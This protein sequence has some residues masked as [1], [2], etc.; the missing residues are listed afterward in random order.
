METWTWSIATM[1]IPEGYGA[2]ALRAA[3]GHLAA[4]HRGRDPP[5]VDDREVA[6]Q[7]G[8]Q[9]AEAV[10]HPGRVGRAPRAGAHRPRPGHRQ[11]GVPARPPPPA[12]PGLQAQPPGG[13]PP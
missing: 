9:A 3:P 5:L 11:P 7:A 6:Q 13:P 8:R 2:L 1:A 12:G 10:L 4:D